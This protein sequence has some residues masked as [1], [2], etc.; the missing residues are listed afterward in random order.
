MFSGDGDDLVVWAHCNSWYI[1][2]H[3]VLC[4]YKS[5]QCSQ[6]LPG[7]WDLVSMAT[8]LI[9]LQVTLCPSLLIDVLSSTDSLCGQGL[10]VHIFLWQRRVE[11]NW[12]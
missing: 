3:C 2:S 10:P 9:T 11:R 5:H 8:V 7:E 1:C 4:S 6:G 12:N